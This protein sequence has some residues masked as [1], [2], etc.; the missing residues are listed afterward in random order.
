MAA[1]A[2]LAL[3]LTQAV[4]HALDQNPTVQ[5]AQETIN[6]FNLQV[7]QVRADALPQLEL[8]MSAQK[9][10]DPGLRNS[11][12]FGDLPDFLPPEALGAYSFDD[13][14]YSFRLEQPIYTFGRVS[15]A[16][17]AARQ[18]LNAVKEE[19]RSVESV[20]A[21]DVAIAYY[22]LLLATERLAVLESEKASRERQLA[23]VKDRLALEDATRLDVL[24]S[25]VALANL[26][27]R[28]LGAENEVAVSRARLNEILSRPIDA[29]LELLDTPAA[30]RPAPL[31]ART[32]RSS[33]PRPLARGRSSSPS[34]TGG[35]CSRRDRRSPVPTPSRRSRP[36]GYARHQQLRRRQPDRP[37]L[38]QLERRASI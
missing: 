18:Q 13:Y 3:T 20:I 8:T 16:L 28:I 19:V 9:F 23:Q 24:N 25:E 7:R 1:P 14:A 10:R 38:P 35:G 30:P 33:S 12:A 26:R 29:P 17:D 37:H 21:R 5:R 32:T 4:E 31:R 36:A 27:P 22:D 34:A 15:G 11:P 6:E 2:P